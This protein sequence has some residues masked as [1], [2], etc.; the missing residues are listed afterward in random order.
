M[1]VELISAFAVGAI[2]G[3]IG[4]AFL[5]VWYLLTQTPDRTAIRSWI[6]TYRT[7]VWSQRD[8]P[9]ELQTGAAITNT[10]F[11]TT[12]GKVV[13]Y[14]FDWDLG[15]RNEQNIACVADAV[16]RCLEIH[17][18]ISAL[19]FLEKRDGPVG[20]LSLKDHL[21]LETGLPAY[22]VRLR[23][24]I[25]TER[26]KPKPSLGVD[27][28]VALLVS[29]VATSGGT[30]QE[31]IDALQGSGIRVAAAIVAFERGDSARVALSHLGVP[32]YSLDHEGSAS[33]VLLPN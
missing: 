30:I 28:P 10:L 29:D 20:A 27:H 21:A 18:D 33:E 2:V 7:A 31:S 25:V 17:R 19:A 14:Y 5:V 3:T 6:G 4:A 16:R 15:A 24:R 32:L 1:L 12:A 13:R 9:L 11:V 8:F 23:K 22:M 26:I